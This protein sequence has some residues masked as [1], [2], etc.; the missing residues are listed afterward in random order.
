[1]PGLQHLGWRLVLTWME[2]D[3]PKKSQ[4][5]GKQWV[6]GG[7][8]DEVTSATTMLYVAVCVCVFACVCFSFLVV[9]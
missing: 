2:G 8:D 9:L 4:T 1:M 3:G 6:G 7:A 5:L